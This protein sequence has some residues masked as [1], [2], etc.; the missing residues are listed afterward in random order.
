MPMSLD[1]KL[2]SFR[3]TGFVLFVVVIMQAGGCSKV[4]PPV[5]EMTFGTADWLFELNKPAPNYIADIGK[6]L[7]LAA[8]K[9]R[10]TVLGLNGQISDGGEAAYFS[11]TGDPNATLRCLEAILP[12]GIFE[13]IDGAEWK[14]WKRDF[15]RFP[16]P[17]EDYP[18]IPQPPRPVRENR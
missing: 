5:I 8:R 2:V 13:V 12:Q 18:D 15:Q 11:T 9:C 14:Q 3:K 6:T 1:R 16:M 17:L 10:S 4:E 7:P